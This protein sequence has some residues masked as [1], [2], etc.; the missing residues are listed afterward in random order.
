MELDFQP[1]ALA[2]L[3]RHTAP[4]GDFTFQPGQVLYT[5]TCPFCGDTNTYTDARTAGFQ[6]EVHYTECE[7]GAE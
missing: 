4:E 1:R 6:S 3:V 5:F 7:R 2:H